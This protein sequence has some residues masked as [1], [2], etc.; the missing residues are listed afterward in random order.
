[1]FSMLYFACIC[2]GL[3]IVNYTK[4]SGLIQ[5]SA[6][7]CSIVIIYCFLSFDPC[8][9]SVLRSDEIIRIRSC[10]MINAVFAS[11]VIPLYCVDRTITVDGLD[12]PGVR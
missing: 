5:L 6:A 10:E 4:K 7:L 9:H 1:M 8:L 11:V 2:T 3:Y 12:N